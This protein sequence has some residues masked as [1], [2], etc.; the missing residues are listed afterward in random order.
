[1]SLIECTTGVVAVFK[2]GTE[3]PVRFWQ[4]DSGSFGVVVGLV[5]H[6]E[7]G[8]PVMTNSVMLY[9]EGSARR[10]EFDHFRWPVPRKRR[11]LSIADDAAE[12]PASD[13][14]AIGEGPE[15]DS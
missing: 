8:S 3:L 2:D 15:G 10:L 6:P 14:K 13:P 1:M 9:S 11:K 7:N 5:A 4:N 12:A